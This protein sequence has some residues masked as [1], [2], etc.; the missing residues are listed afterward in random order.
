MWLA[1]VLLSALGVI[2]GLMLGFAARWFALD[3]VDPMISEV[4]ALMPES[5]CGQRSIQRYTH[6]PITLVPKQKT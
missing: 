6:K 2:L 1:I 4:Q 3:D 5:Q